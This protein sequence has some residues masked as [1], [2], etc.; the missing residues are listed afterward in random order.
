MTFTSYN[1]MKKGRQREKER[2]NISDTFILAGG[3]RGRGLPG[4]KKEKTTSNKRK[5]LVSQSLSICEAQENH[6][7]VDSS[8]LQKRHEAHCS[9]SGGVYK[10]IVSQ[11]GEERQRC[12]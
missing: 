6:D 3:E 8:H 1:N 4:R 9:G 11:G 7:K 2:V 5:H 10:Y 12:T